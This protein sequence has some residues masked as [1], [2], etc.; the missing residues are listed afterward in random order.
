MAS[1]SSRTVKISVTVDRDVL[2]ELKK[3]LR[4]RDESLSAYISDAV[5]NAVRRENMRALLDD[6]ERELGPVSEKDRRAARAKLAGA[7]GARARRRSR[8][9]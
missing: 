4:Q 8:A 6:L 7:F 5:A 2:V 1:R 3:R 9:A